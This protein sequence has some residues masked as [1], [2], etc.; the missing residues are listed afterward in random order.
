MACPDVPLPDIFSAAAPTALS[1]I[2]AAVTASSA[3]FAPV[4][5]SADIWLVSI[6]PSTNSLESTE[7]AA[8][9]AAVIDAS[10]ISTSI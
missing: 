6:L 10:S 7:F 4:T 5:A 2:L 9:S 3:I 1:V 8:S